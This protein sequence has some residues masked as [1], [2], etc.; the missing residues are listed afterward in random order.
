[1]T[2]T[3]VKGNIIGEKIYKARLKKELSQVELAASMY[4]DKG[5]G[6]ERATI[7][8]IERGVRAVKDKEIEAFCDILDVTPNWLFGY[9]G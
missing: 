3:L 4:V 6:M 8:Q 1:M 7:S 5:I 9:K 2:T